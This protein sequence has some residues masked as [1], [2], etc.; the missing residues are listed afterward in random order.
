[1]K[2]IIFSLTICLLL[3]GLGLPAFAQKYSREVNEPGYVEAV[4]RNTDGA[5]VSQPCYIHAATIYASS[6]SAS[7]ALYDATSA[8][9]GPNIVSNLKIE[10]GEATQY[11]SN[12]IEFTPPIKMNNGVYVDVTNAY[13]IIEYR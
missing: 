4:A 7:I 3:L 13:A 2:K 5:L 10:I 6:G 1:M 12:R 8:A 11:E 9:T